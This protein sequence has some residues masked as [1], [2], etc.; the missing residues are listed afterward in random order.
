MSVSASRLVI[1]FDGDDTLWHNEQLFADTQHQLRELLGHYADMTTIDSKLLEI[2]R[3]NLAIFGYG[4]KGFIVSMIE[5]AIEISDSRVDARDIHQIVM[6]GKALLEH[7]IALLD[8]VS[9]VVEELASRHRLILVTKGDLL[10]Q[11]TK[12][13]ASGLADLFWQI[14]IVSEKDPPTYRRL[15]D[16]HAVSPV[17]FVM[18]GNSI[19][20]DVLPVLA[21]GGRAVHVPYHITWAL[22]VAAADNEDFPTL[23]DLRDVLTIV[24][25][26]SS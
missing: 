22:E 10:H 8:G 18:I 25:E 15:L 23:A 3:R 6:L 2:E 21:I 17:D 9:D 24:E 5:T 7:P 4:V 19:A 1:G 13:A 14:E 11:E 26:W 20:S 12:V 16:R